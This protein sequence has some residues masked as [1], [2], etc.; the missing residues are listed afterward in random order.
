[1]AETGL[2][3]FRLDGRVALVTGGASGIGLAAS[4]VLARA[5]A[6]VAIH[7]HT[8]ATGAEGAA[9]KIRGQGGEA[10]TLGADLT[11][12]GEADRVVAKT[13]EAFAGLDIL[14]N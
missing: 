11:R 7:Y 8:S 2:G 5:G 6:R 14:V 12:A 4:L 13:I 1:M 3:G 10:L 9:A